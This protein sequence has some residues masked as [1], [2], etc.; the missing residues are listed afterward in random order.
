MRAPG[1][2][3]PF[4]AVKQVTLLMMYIIHVT[5]CSAS[6]NGCKNNFNWPYMYMYVSITLSSSLPGFYLDKL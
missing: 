4:Y 3:Y 6:T 5:T 1:A 2:G